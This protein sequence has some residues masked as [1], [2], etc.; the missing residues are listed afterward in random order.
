MTSWFD[1]VMG[2]SRAGARGEPAPDALA[3]FPWDAISDWVVRV[4]RDGAVVD[5]NR[6][7]GAPFPEVRADDLG[8]PVHRLFPSK[9]SEVLDELIPRV[10]D[11]RVA[12]TF[13]YSFGEG[14]YAEV[15][16]FPAG[17]GHV[18][19]LARDLSR[20]KA[21]EASLR[22]GK[23]R[24]AL[25]IQGANDGLWDWLLVT[26]EVYYSL[27]WKAML[28]VDDVDLPPTPESWFERVHPEDFERVRQDLTKHLEGETPRFE[29][30]HRIR[31][32]DGDWLWVL[33]RGMALRD[34]R[35]KATRIAGS[36]TD[37]THR[38]VV[39]AAAEKGRLLE[40][41]TRAVG[42]GI[43]L[44]LPG[45]TLAQ[46]SPTL[47]DMVSAWADPEGWWG[48][49]CAAAE[50][51][52]PMRCPTCQRRQHVGSMLAEVTTPGGEPRV[53]EVTVTGHAH[54]VHEEGQ[55]H[56][57][58]VEDVTEQK[59]AERRLEQLN[60]ELIV[61]RD[62][63]LASSRA[64]STFLANMS[65]ELR[66]PLNAVLGYS[67][68]LLEELEEEGSEVGLEELQRIQAA[69]TQLLELITSVLDLSK[70]EAGMMALEVAPFDLGPFLD[71]VIALG[72]TRAEEA[73][74]RFTWTAPEA[75]GEVVT[76]AGKLR[77]VLLQL[78][79]N[80]NKFTE[81]GEVRLDVTE[82]A[83]DL[84]F[85]VTDTGIGIEAQA[86]KQLFQDFYQGDLS[87]TKRFG[88]AGLGL[89]LCRRFVEL[90]GGTITVESEPGLGSAFRVRLPRRAP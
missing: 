12:A 71:E 73:G 28:G 6:P 62:E 84:W 31:H 26:G 68:M 17:D 4:R 20:R 64:K 90:M 78:L 22:R 79:G 10:L 58:L 25:A 8:R 11:T 49:V 1:Q 67:E 41:A 24:Y 43:L 80:A 74:N 3:P 55:A 44:L 52:R 29:T 34:A 15:R 50:L 45:G 86:L 19:L 23:E 16:M 65:H 40:Y 53:F 5:S 36:L 61:A 87:T 48:D 27:Q 38:R 46:I 13:E 54:E 35:G 33:A 30:E 32:A 83:D 51:P 69:G 60:A 76:D 42:I 18:V 14:S 47:S 39:A 77:Q 59:L 75:S 9:V 37:L 66:T 70:V 72:R 88:G 89:A 7:P 2:K 82:D 56:V 57:V 85:S 21:T 63:A 81:G